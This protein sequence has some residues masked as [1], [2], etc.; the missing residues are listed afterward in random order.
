MTLLWQVRILV[1]AQLGVQAVH[2]WL[3]LHKGASVMAPISGA[4]ALGF[5]VWPWRTMCRRHGVKW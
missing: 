3:F 5:T 4:I 1:L 2:W